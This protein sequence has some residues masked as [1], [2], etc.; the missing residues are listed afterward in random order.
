MPIVTPTQWQG[1]SGVTLTDSQTASVGAICTEVDAAIKRLCR[2]WLFE[3]ATF[4]NVILDAP[5]EDI[6]TLPV[7]PVRSISSL[8]VNWNANGDPSQFTSEFLLTN[9]TDYLLVIDDQVN[10]YSKH[11]FVRR[12][13]GSTWFTG[14][15][16]WGSEYRSAAQRLAVELVPCRGAVMVSFAAGSLAI[17]E[18]VKLAANLA[19]SMVFN[20]R[21]LGMPVSSNSWNGES[22]SFAGPFTTE[23]VLQSPDIAGYLS[24]YQAPVFGAA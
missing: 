17:P 18:E 10:N 23:G 2:P 22:V 19:V 8:Y 16:N 3:P 15:G 13:S 6:L 14:G 5:L 4:T 7:M 21:K 1:F 12:R 9:F 20:R 11:G 24:G